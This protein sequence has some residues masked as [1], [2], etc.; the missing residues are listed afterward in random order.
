MIDELSTV[1]TVA[2]GLF[3][4]EIR[5]DNQLVEKHDCSSTQVDVKSNMQTEC[6]Y[7]CHEL[8][9]YLHE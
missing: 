7:T 2:A 4:V 8:L 3:A 1:R 6:C 5:Q 9:V